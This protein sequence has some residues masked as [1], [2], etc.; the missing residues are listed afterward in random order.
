M[1][2]IVHS[3]YSAQ[4]IGASLGKAEY[5]YYF[6][7]A[8][9][10]P[11][12]R[13]LGD[14]VTV[15]NPETEADAIFDAAQAAGEGCVFLCF[16]PPHL[17]P[18]TLR[19]P[20]IPV[21][22][23]EFSTIPCEMWDEDPRSDWRVVFA[24]CKRAIALS[25][26]T[27]ALIREA[28][29]TDFPVFAIPT[30]SYE[31]FA[32]T[33]AARPLHEEHRLHCQGYLFDSATDEA[34][35]HPP[36]WPPEPAPHF[37]PPLPEVSLPP[38]ESPASES[39]VPAAPPPRHGL[40]KRLSIT[41]WYMRA[42]Y[43]DAVRDILPAALKRLAS[44]SGRGAYRAMQMVRRPPPP[45]PPPPAPELPACD[46]V[47][48]GV[49]YASVL[50]PQDGR[51]NWPDLV[52]AF[53]WAFRDNPGATLFLKMPVRGGV[54]VFPDLHMFLRRFAPFQCRIISFAGFLDD[55]AYR[56]L[57]RA[58]T[59]YANASHAEGL[60]LPLMEF[61]SAGRP[62]IAPNHTAMA[63]YITPDI[64]FIARA[65]L[66]HNVWPFDPRDLF[67]TMYYRLNWQSLVDAY[68]RSFAVA[69]APDGRYAAMSNAAQAAMRDF[70]AVDVV[71][72]KLA[73]ALEIPAGPQAT[74]KNSVVAA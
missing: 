73:E 35:S 10:L 22:A 67:T 9:Y 50:A 74:R 24:H 40:R 47:L 39:P 29:G 65:S 14:V 25:T 60:C 61:L 56:G 31:P 45:P 48:S 16:A 5:S 54:E 4:T 30:A 51:K 57:I 8:G 72:G 2:I 36:V 7:L 42:W 46:I 34:F 68:V 41:V 3:S 49:V 21:V 13:A 66:I 27:A 15:D 58:A 12:L 52:N 53:L 28:M 20:T 44:A 62:A 38:S 37:G 71:R 11:A 43:H 32:D 6:V 64:A 19:C 63:D 55:A 23:W 17:V 33:G 18:I 1:K 26:H 69:E 70:C 59:Y